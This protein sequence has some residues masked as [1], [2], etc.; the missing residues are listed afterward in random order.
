MARKKEAKNGA[1]LQRWN[2]SKR[3]GFGQVGGN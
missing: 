1:S 2:D 3:P